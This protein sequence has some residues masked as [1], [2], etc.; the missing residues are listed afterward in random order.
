[1]KQ[2]YIDLTAVLK[3]DIRVLKLLIHEGEA[4]VAKNR[5]TGKLRRI[6]VKA[7]YQHNK[8]FY[9]VEGSSW[10]Y[11]IPK[12]T[13]DEYRR[14]LES[15][16]EEKGGQ[17]VPQ[18]KKE[19]PS[20]PDETQPATGGN[21][22]GSGGKMPEGE[23][24]AEA[25]DPHME[26]MGGDYRRI[27]DMEEDE[28][29]SML[30][31]YRDKLE[32]LSRREDAGREEKLEAIVDAGRDSAL[33]NKASID[34]AFS[35]GDEE[36]KVLT[37]PVVEETNHMIRSLLKVMVGE[38]MQDRTFESLVSRSNG[39]VV[40][41]MT[42]TF[43][44]GVS[45]ILYYNQQVTSTGIISRMRTKFR[46]NF[47]KY[48]KTLLPHLLPD[49]INL[50]RVFMGGM[51]ALSE[52]EL[53]AITTGF[54]VHDIGKVDDIEYHEGEAGYD[55]QTVERHVKRG[56]HAIMNKTNYTREAGLITGYHHEYYGDSAGYGY[57]REFLE[58]YLKQNPKART[59][60]CIAYNMEAIVDYEAL[61]FF[62]A[63]VLEIVD[64]YDALTD[65]NRK[66]R[67]PLSPSDAIEL[68]RTQFIEEHLKVDPILFEIFIAYMKDQD[69]L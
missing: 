41:H 4:V 30:T 47:H 62:P 55:R 16:D 23:S 2:S 6:P 36:A 9:L 10:N 46:K 17:A 66:Y 37:A 18:S 44:N 22:A 12:D 5:K 60:Y 15:Q 43:I 8:R 50:E 57:F 54:L 53:H 49:Q 63:K 39:T 7:L 42:R 28:R 59:D 14:R 40:Q 31:G 51:R 13:A 61:A 64:I 26:N 3:S 69:L 34:D 19:G 48:Y 65:P 11:Y 21:A 67:S 56:Y 27:K 24:P 38:A 25:A 20:A 35:K 45:F 52:E 68:I 58:N 29:L 1:M 32:E 33:I